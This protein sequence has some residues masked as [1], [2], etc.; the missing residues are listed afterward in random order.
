MR[1]EVKLPQDIAIAIR[2]FIDPLV[3]NTE[4]GFKSA[5]I[6]AG[7][8]FN[9]DTSLGSNSTTSPKRY[10]GDVK[11][12]S[13]SA[14]QAREQQQE[15]WNNEGIDLHNLTGL[16]V[17]RRWFLRLDVRS[18]YSTTDSRTVLPGSYPKLGYLAH[19][20]SEGNVSSY[21]FLTM[22]PIN[23]GI[24]TING[25]T[26]Y[27]LSIL[28]VLDGVLTG[29]GP[30]MDYS[31]NRLDLA[32]SSSRI[33]YTW[34][35]GALPPATLYNGAA[36]RLRSL[37]EV[38]IGSY[39]HIRHTQPPSTVFRGTLNHAVSN[40]Y[41]QYSASGRLNPELVQVNINGYYCGGLTGTNKKDFFTTVNMP[42]LLFYITPP[43][44][45][46]ERTTVLTTSD[47]MPLDLINF[48]GANGGPTLYQ[49]TLISGAATL[50]IVKTEFNRNRIPSVHYANHLDY[51]DLTTQQREGLFG[52]SVS[53]S[54]SGETVVETITRGQSKIVSFL[55][56]K[57][58]FMFFVPITETATSSVIEIRQVT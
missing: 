58:P 15:L 45:P 49:V 53:P 33:F 23:R 39:P 36:Y 56:K 11:G 54:A 27:F 52:F 4:G 55:T 51:S 30:I 29:R 18:Q 42:T 24:E 40:R 31:T 7:T 1:K 34:P 8:E 3:P 43:A 22:S 13:A 25:T 48:W 28:L 35:S 32:V 5:Y 12:T 14:T 37:N 9:I 47:S 50:N 46:A 20:D 44:S 6:P 41:F 2:Q 19:L 57:I 21:Q 26:Y 17:D 10:I 16:H 38:I